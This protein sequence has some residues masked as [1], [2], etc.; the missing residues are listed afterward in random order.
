MKKCFNYWCNIQIP[1]NR[2]YCDDQCAR[3]ARLY[4]QEYGI[5]SNVNNG[6]ALLGNGKKFSQITSSETAHA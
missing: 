5:E 2:K 6:K 3:F 4:R 1:D